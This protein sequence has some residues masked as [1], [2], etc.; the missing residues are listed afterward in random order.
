MTPADIIFL[1]FCAAAVCWVAHWMRE[2]EG[3]DHGRLAELRDK[4]ERWKKQDEEMGRTINCRCSYVPMLE[5]GKPSNP[6]SDP[7]D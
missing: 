3:R 1:Y 6:K 4:V 2:W 5:Y 7:T